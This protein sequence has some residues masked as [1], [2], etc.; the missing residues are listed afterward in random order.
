MRR[1]SHEVIEKE[2]ALEAAI[3]PSNGREQDE[4]N[5]QETITLLDV[6]EKVERADYPDVWS[7][8]LKLLSIM[9]TSVGCERTFSILKHKLHPNMKKE[10]A[11]VFM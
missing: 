6:F 1:L 5:M 3:R 11:I 9:P 4:E 8:V 10:N 2:A 7:E